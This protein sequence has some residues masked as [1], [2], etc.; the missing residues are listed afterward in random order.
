MVC[1]C[2]CMCIYFLYLIVYLM[3]WLASACSI[4]SSIASWN[5]GR[6]KHHKAK[7]N[8]H[9]LAEWM[10][11]AFRP[12]LVVCYWV[13][14]F[15]NHECLQC[16]WESLYVNSQLFLNLAGKANDVALV[17]VHF[18]A[19]ASPLRIRQIVCASLDSSTQTTNHSIADEYVAHHGMTNNTAKLK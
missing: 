5:Q 3:N 8:D 9:R 4:R 13:F 14:C 10:R 7:G 19:V 18:K 2:A 1:V 12:K 15:L 11:R 6:A 16:L 17:N